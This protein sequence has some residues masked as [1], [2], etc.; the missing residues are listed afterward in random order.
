LLQ[1]NLHVLNWNEQLLY[2][3]LALYATLAT[4]AAAAHLAKTYFQQQT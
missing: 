1:E 2:I 4:A 3:T